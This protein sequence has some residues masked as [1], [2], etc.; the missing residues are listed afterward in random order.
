MPAYAEM[1]MPAY[2]DVIS[3]HLFATC[4]ELALNADTP[5]DAIRVDNEPISHS[6]WLEV[7]L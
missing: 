6:V 7:G 4:D 3:K 5:Q 1:G 2:A